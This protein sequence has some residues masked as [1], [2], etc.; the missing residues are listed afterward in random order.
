MDCTSYLNTGEC[1]ATRRSS[2]S[3]GGLR[4]HDTTV[5][6]MSFGMEIIAIIN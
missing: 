1:R 3:A 4:Q 6:L 2:G 5:V